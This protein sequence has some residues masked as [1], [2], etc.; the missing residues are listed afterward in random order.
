MSVPPQKTSTIANTYDDIMPDLPDNAYY[1]TYIV[2]FFTGT[3][4]WFVK[5][6]D[7]FSIWPFYASTAILTFILGYDVY[8][9]YDA[10]SM[11]YFMMF[12]VV[13]IAAGCIMNLVSSAYFG[14]TLEKLRSSFAQSNS[15]VELDQKYA[16]LLLWFQAFWVVSTVLIVIASKYIYYTP[17]EVSSFIIR[18]LSLLPGM[19]IGIHAIISLVLFILIFSLGITIYDIIYTKYGNASDLDEFRKYFNS[20]AGVMMTL[21][22]SITGI[23]ILKYIGSLPTRKP[24]WKILWLILLGSIFILIMTSLPPKNKTNDPSQPVL[25]KL[26]YFNIF[27]SILFALTIIIGVLAYFFTRN[28]KNNY[29]FLSAIHLD[30]VLKAI[31]FMT[32]IISTV[33]SGL[34]FNAFIMIPDIQFAYKPSHFYQIFFSFIAFVFFY[35]FITALFYVFETTAFNIIRFVQW[36]VPALI[37]A[38]SGYQI[39]IGRI[40][41]ELLNATKAE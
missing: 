18:Y 3:M 20:L 26:R 35:L 19:N 31:R 15:K 5:M 10:R 33:L 2:L 41:S 24:V 29:A 16:E 27:G 37:I 21:F 7:A 6:R 1:F 4:L 14:F 30:Y 23:E 17:S 32:I 36:G 8:N 22:F 38:F 34:L 11:S 28:K 39:H 25:K 9:H 13:F 12:I 40:F